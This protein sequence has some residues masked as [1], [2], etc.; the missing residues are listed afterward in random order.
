M[1]SGSFANITNDFGAKVTVKDADGNTYITDNPS[2][3]S[4][5][6]EYHNTQGTYSVLM[7]ASG[8]PNSV[9]TSMTGYFKGYQKKPIIGNSRYG[10]IKKIAIFR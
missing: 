5:T 9:E 2:S 4:N 7:K 3:G 1:L 8:K 10:Y 6:I